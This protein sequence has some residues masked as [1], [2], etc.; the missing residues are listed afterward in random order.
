MTLNV[1]IKRRKDS[2]GYD[3]R[4]TYVDDFLITAKDP[5]KYMAFFQTVYTIKDPGEPKFC[6]LANYIRSPNGKWFIMAKQ[7]LKEAINQIEKKFEILIQEE[8]PPI[9]TDDH[10]EEDDSPLLDNMLHKEY[11]SLIGM[12]QWAVTLCH[13]DICYA[14][15]SM[16]RFSAAPREGHLSRV[17]RIWGYLKKYPNRAIYV[18]SIP[19][20][21]EDDI[22]QMTLIVIPSEIMKRQ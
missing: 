17:L 15:S 9:K 19:L 11:Q 16:G 14:A 3:Y 5:D 2:Q 4:S 12:L 8:N 10:P 6:L 21:Y 22:C 1:W 13:V 20:R 18:S 7:Y